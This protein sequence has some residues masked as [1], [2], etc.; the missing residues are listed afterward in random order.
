M[1]DGVREDIAT[2]TEDDG[3]G[4]PA[5][6]FEAL[7]QTIERRGIEIG[8][9][10]TVIRKGV[11]AAFDRFDK[12][13]VPPDYGADLGRIVQQ[14]GEMTERLAG[15]EQS[16]VLRQGADHYTRALERSGEGLVRGAVQQLQHQ[17]AALERAGRMLAA[18][19]NSA[20]D[21]EVQRRHLWLTMV[22]GILA[23]VVLGAF[24]TLFVPRILPA[25]IQLF[26][27]TTVTNATDG[28]NAGAMLMNATN[29]NGWAAIVSDRQF[30]QDN[31]GAISSITACVEAAAKAGKEQKCSYTV[32]VPD[33]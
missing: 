3:A 11:E 30:A 18:H 6:A 33:K 4:D 32:A 15:V 28:W 20:N 23:G 10:M 14:L 7:R 5:V 22:V 21:W 19:T 16:P 29:P 24:V 31:R 13:T 2:R 27:A 26:V 12:I 25:S 17:A 8:A 1:T 9:E